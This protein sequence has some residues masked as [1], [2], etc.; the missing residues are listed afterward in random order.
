MQDFRNFDPQRLERLEARF[1]G[2]RSQPP[3]VIDDDSSQSAGSHSS[4]AEDSE[5]QVL[6][7]RPGV[8]FTKSKDSS[9]TR[10]YLGRILRRFVKDKKGSTPSNFHGNSPEPVLSWVV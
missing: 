1:K 7:V 6:Q 10:P 4:Q 9:L 8:D 5:I 3:I 2:N